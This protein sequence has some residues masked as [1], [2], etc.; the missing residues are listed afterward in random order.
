MG[1]KRVPTGSKR[2]NNGITR[3]PPKPTPCHRVSFGDWVVVTAPPILG[4]GK[5]KKNMFEKV[6]GW[7]GCSIQAQQVVGPLNLTR[8]PKI[9]KW[10]KSTTKMGMWGPSAF[11]SPPPLGPK[12]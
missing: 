5:L 10:A 11:P 4:A 9:A 1:P 2:V 3:Q 6:F 8:V 12:G 7:S